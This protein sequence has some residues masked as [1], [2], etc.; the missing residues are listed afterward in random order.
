MVKL[1]RGDSGHIA[2]ISIFGAWR[3]ITG[4]WLGRALWRF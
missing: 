4:T 1:F 2:G 3:Q